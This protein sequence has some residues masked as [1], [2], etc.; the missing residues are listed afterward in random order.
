MAKIHERLASER[1]GLWESALTPL[2]LTQVA[3]I[4]EPRWSPDG[5]RVSY[6][7]TRNGEGRVLVLP[8]NGGLEVQITT[9]PSAQ[10]GGSYAG[11][12]YDWSP[13]GRSIVY[14]ARD[15]KLW[16]VPSQGGRSRRL[17]MGDADRQRAPAWS[18]DGRWVAYVSDTSDE[19][20]IAVAEASPTH[21]GSAWPRRLSG[22][23]DFVQDPAWSPD[24]RYLA[25]QEWD[26]PNMP[27]DGSRIVLAEV[28]TGERR[29]V[30]GGDDVATSQPRFS[31]DGRS[32]AFL[33][34]RSGW[35]NLWIAGADGS[36]ARP[37]VDESFEHGPP[38]WS[39]GTRTFAWSPDGEQIAYLRN[40]DGNW[41]VRIVD[42]AT[43]ATRSVDDSDGA[44]TGIAWSSRNELVFV[45]SLSTAPPSLVAV[46]LETGTART[47]AMGYKL[48]SSGYLSRRARSR[49][50]R[51][52]L[53]MPRSALAGS[54][55]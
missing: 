21:G 32:L 19:S 9:D 52:R 7:H 30:A 14:L 18:P 15:G 35:L 45:H 31:P 25:W 5:E 53:T 10:P 51:R 22:K 33:S 26:V 36:G 27:W 29:I 34:D 50:L 2:M 17:A 39:P 55:K 23:A 54:A 3:G 42:V 41:R 4:G 24:S 47:L 13:D 20:V 6:L 43:G 1:P 37:L 49:A 48:S 8:S 28:A 40:D 11:G 16:I 44:R 38:T 12:F 46:N